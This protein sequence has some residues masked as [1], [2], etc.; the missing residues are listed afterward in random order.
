MLD[1]WNIRQH[2]RIV[3]KHQPQRR[4]LRFV[5]PHAQPVDQGSRSYVVE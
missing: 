1:Q 5:N 3:G 4:R 2:H